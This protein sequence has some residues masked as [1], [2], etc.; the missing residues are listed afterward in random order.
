MMHVNHGTVSVLV[1][2]AL[3]LASGYARAETKLT[4]FNGTW[5]GNGTDRNTPLESSQQTHCRASINADVV[6]MGAHILCNGAAGLTKVI[7]LNITLARD[8]FS[9]TLSQKATTRGSGARESDLGGSVTGHKTDKTADFT[10]SFPGLTPSVSV[11][12][13]LISPGSFSMRATTLGGQLM[14]VTF[15]RSSPR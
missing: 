13:T 14:D 12:L 9:G 10:V 3:G 4:D 1:L 5:Q 7:Q 6:R 8:A 15:R 2:L 11:V